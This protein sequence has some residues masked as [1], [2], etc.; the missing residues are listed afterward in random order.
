MIKNYIKIAFRNL[1]KYRGY[2]A[3]NIVGLAIGITCAGLILLWMENQYNYN[4]S[5][6]DKDLV[7]AVPTSQK[8]DGVW[9]TFVGATPGQLAEDLAKEIPEIETSARLFNADLMFTV[10]DIAIYGNSAY[11]DAAIFEI[12]GHEFILGNSQEAFTDKQSIVISKSVA[13]NLFG[14]Y[15]EAFGKEILINKTD[16]YKITGITKDLPETSTYTF[17]SFIPFSNFTDGREWTQGYGGNF[18]TTFVKLKPNADFAAADQ[19][20]RALMPPNTERSN[21]IAILYSANDWHLW[22]NFENGEIVGGRIEFVR[23]FGLIA[24]IILSIAC[25]N[26]MNISTARSEKR[27]SEVG[28]RKALGSR[29]RQLIFQFLS[30]SL[31]TATFSGILSM[32][33]L[34]AIIPEFNALLNTQISLDLGQPSHLLS[35][36]SIII[37]CGLL[38]GLYPAFYLSSFKP[39][40][41]LKGTFKAK[42]SAANVRKGLVVIQ[43]SVSIIFIIST[44]LIY[45]QV[46]HVKNRDL[47]IVKENLV[48]IPNS[49]NIIENFDLIQQDLKTAGVIKSAALCNSAV[50][51]GGN[52]ISDLEWKGKPADQDIL[53]SQRQITQDYFNTTGMKILEGKGFRATEAQDSISIII[54]KSLADLI[55]TQPIVGSKVYWGDWELNVR[56][57]VSNYQYDDMY[58]KSDPVFFYHRSVAARFLY[59]KPVDGIDMQEAIAKIKEVLSVHNAGFP[60]EYSFVD[61]AFEA[62]FRTENLIGKLSQIFALLAIFISCLGLFG[63]SAYTA[64]QRR[65]EIGVRKVLGSSVS[66]IVRL[67]SLDFVKLIGIAI[68]IAI[69]VG[70]YLMENWLQGFA[71]RIEINIWIFL[72]AAL[73]AV[74]I[75]SVTVSFQAIKAAVVNPIKSLK[76]E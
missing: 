60:F 47:G 45:Q 22:N 52:N 51:S 16:N 15:E 38:A 65:K 36:F 75:A 64:E 20:V 67:L 70:Y 69:P 33:M 29:K 24:L 54:S 10:A 26:F 39:I 30:E 9:R 32:I 1:W 6:P 4:E 23:L 53:I 27:A 62:R 71:Y 31:L 58:A 66:N 41:T 14:S 72:V 25:I 76:T 11:A 2:S 17:T 43:F 63:L 13:E 35:I 42:G 5:I 28:M 56:G 50:L 57:V 48:Q 8:Y 73:S 37:L 59:L 3:L 68:L 34:V 55:G 18:A 74:A 19:K 61:D 44:I 40:A 49:G 21:T 46:Q 12:F 7:Y